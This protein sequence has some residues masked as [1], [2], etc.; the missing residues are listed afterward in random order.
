LNIIEVRPITPPEEREKSK[1]HTKVP[2]RK[3]I[4]TGD[5]DLLLKHLFAGVMEE[6]KS[7]QNSN[8]AHLK[9]GR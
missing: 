1:K 5:T 8:A 3:V 4:V 7:T 9:R 6:K 2:E